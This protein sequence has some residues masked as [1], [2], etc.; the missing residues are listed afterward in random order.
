MSGSYYRSRSRSP[1]RDRRYRHKYPEYHDNKSFTKD[2]N[3]KH[4]N[5]YSK[6]EYSGRDFEGSRRSRGQS[7]YDRP[8]RFRSS[9]YPTSNPNDIPTPPEPIYDLKP[10]EPILNPNPPDPHEQIY[11]QHSP[12]PSQIL[13]LGPKHF[14]ESDDHTTD[15]IS[16][17]RD[18]I[19]S[20]TVEKN[21]EDNPDEWNGFPVPKFYKGLRKFFD[22]VSRAGTEFPPSLYFPVDGPKIRRY[23]AYKCYTD[24]LNRSIDATELSNDL[25][26]TMS[27]E[28]EYLKNKLEVSNILNNFFR[29]L[30]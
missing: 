29:L 24:P 8:K 13:T 7:Q 2:N 11:R 19:K 6:D 4:Y 5:S 3:Y 18:D 15:V 21:S 12:D 14:K 26:A 23:K 20:E 10:P 17:S 22:P 30:K 27:R 25:T 1:Q 16:T 28:F 9:S